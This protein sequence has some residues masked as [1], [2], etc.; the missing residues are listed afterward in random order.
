[1]PTAPAIAA[2]LHDLDGTWRATLPM[3]PAAPTD[4]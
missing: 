4:D 3:K 2:A 1:V